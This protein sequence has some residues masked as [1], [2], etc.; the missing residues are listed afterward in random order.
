MKHFAV[1]LALVALATP[2]TVAVAQ[3]VDSPPA[4]V[5][6]AAWT[7]DEILDAIRAVET[8]GEA[9]DGQRASG[10]G[11]RAIGPYQIHRGCFQDAGVAGRYEDCRD[12]EFA[13]RVV[14]AY[15]QRWCPKALERRDAEI[16][17][18]VHNG[19]P[20]GAGKDATLAFW[21]KVEQR[22]AARG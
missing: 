19:G 22:L 17:A 12:P 8:G 7:L 15:W 10:D 20:K 16:L 6:T 1:V 13:R 4:P 21:R 11:G 9:G 5:A 18:R 2:A 14:I 3:R